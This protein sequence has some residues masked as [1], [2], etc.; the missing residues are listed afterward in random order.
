MSVCIAD[1]D[2]MR[3]CR[4]LELALQPNGW[5]GNVEEEITKELYGVTHNSPVVDDALH[6]E[7]G[8]EQL[9]DDEQ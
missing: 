1:A 7:T 3:Q 8:A 5:R 2:V 9:G 4:K 6:E